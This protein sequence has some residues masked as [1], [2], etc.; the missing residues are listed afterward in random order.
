MVLLTP[1]RVSTVY[2]GNGRS[3]F[4]AADDS[5]AVKARRDLDL[6]GISLLCEWDVLTFLYRHVAS[7]T[8]AGQIAGLLGYGKAG[9]EAALEKLDSLRLVKRSRSARG[10]CIYRLD[11]SAD[12]RH[13]CFLDLMSL[14]EKR[15]GRLL[16]ATA[17]RRPTRREEAEQ[18]D[19]LHLA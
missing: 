19:G 12:P 7:L 8:G 15:S 2:P 1:Q 4:M 6:L 11:L 9:V 18:R 10:L 13:G 5:P 17:L 14:A 3:N 16:V